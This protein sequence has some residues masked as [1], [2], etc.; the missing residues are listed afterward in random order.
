MLLRN[1]SRKLTYL[2]CY[3]DGKIRFSELTNLMDK[4]PKN[5][6]ISPKIPKNLSKSLITGDESFRIS[7]TIVYTKKC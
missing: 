4:S 7:F 3:L 6:Q 2:S 1:G 5:P